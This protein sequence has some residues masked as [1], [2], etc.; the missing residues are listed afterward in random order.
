MSLL[1]VTINDPS[2]GRKS[3]E[4]NY[5]LYTLNEVAK[6]LGRGQGT[7]TTGTILGQPATGL[8]PSSLG[9]WTYTPSAS[10]P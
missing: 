8:G 3:D 2:L 1:S 7:V 5:L 4:V 6:E 9:S 10:N